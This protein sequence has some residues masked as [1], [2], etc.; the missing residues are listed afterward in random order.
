M[1]MIGGRKKCTYHTSEHEKA[2]MDVQNDLI[3]A[4]SPGRRCEIALAMYQTAWDL[5]VCGLRAQHPDW[6]ESQV[7]AKTR[8][9]F[10]TGY[11]GD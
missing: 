1:D 10:L 9:I 3:R 11:A 8:K 5:K 4:M 2:A 6:S 7:L